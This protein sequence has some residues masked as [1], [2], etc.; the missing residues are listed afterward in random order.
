MTSTASPFQVATG[1]V[2]RWLDTEGAAFVSRSRRRDAR[3]KVASWEL[4]LEHPTYGPQSVLLSLPHDFPA[5]SPQIHFPHKLCLQLPH[6]EEDGK[7]CHGVDPSSN[8][9]EDPRG[10]VIEVLRKLARYWEDVANPAWVTAEFQRERLAYWSRFCSLSY[11][12]G[13]TPTPRNTRAAL[14]PITEV[15]EGKLASYHARGPGR[16]ASRRD[17][18]LRSSRLLATVG[19][20]DPH[21]LAVQHGWAT[22]TLLRGEV[23]WIP[24]PTDWPWTPQ[25]WP[26]SL[27][28]LEH[29]VQEVTGESHSVIAWLKEKIEQNTKRTAVREYHP[30]LVVLVQGR[31]CFGYLITPNLVPGLTAPEVVP[32]EIDRIDADWALARDHKLDTLEA[33]REKRV[34]LV[35]CGSVGAPI[36]DLLAR[37]GVGELHLADK[38]F[39]SVENCARHVLGAT[40]IG[41]AKATVLAESIRRQIPG[42]RVRPLRVL[43]ADWVSQACSPGQY[44]LV[45][46]CTGESSVRT[47]LSRFRNQ[48]FGN[49]GIVHVWLEPF[50]AA[51]H[52]VYA[53]AQLPWPHDDPWERINAAMWPKDVR[54]Q[55]PACSS[56]FHPYGAADA[57]QAAGF[58]T[59][60]ILACLDNDVSESTVWSWVRSSA[61]FDKLDV[62]ATRSS[63]IPEGASSFE[64]A[65]VVRTL[66]SALTH[67]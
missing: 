35:G 16:A 54:V 40:H 64:A 62:A 1:A 49:A 34:L 15:V 10:V 53:S 58:A 33:R 17:K 23:L 30:K 61:Y 43:A 25:D 39:F 52:A 60:R 19:E 47:M 13:G 36:A 46:D 14:T 48:A 6:I 28:H 65:H 24:L 5:S 12:N 11:K 32:V 44:D 41:L 22:G 45:I 42:T 9:Y 67:E 27:D 7:F 59:E 29:L 3:R 20:T 38:E 56:G 18:E 8:D 31:T 51:A 57:W 26:R 63:I 21:A 55:L 66:E 4:T 2:E 37:A 50:G